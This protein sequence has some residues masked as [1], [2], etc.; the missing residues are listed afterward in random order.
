MNLKKI[1]IIKVDLAENINLK[2][3]WRT[4]MTKWHKKICFNLE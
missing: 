2:L 4:K 1:F 3:V